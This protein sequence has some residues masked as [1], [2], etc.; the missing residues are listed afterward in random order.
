[1]VWIT[2][3]YQTKTVIEIKVDFTGFNSI[4]LHLINKIN[5]YKLRTFQKNTTQVSKD[6]DKKIYHLLNCKEKL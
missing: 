5:R 6:I 3:Q 4:F 2:I 1:M